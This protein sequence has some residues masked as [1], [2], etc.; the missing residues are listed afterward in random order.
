[1]LDDLGLIP[2]LHSFCKSLATR[3]KL[4]IQLTAFGG[5]EA[6]A[7]DKRTVLFRVAQEAL[8]NVARHARAT[9]VKFTIVKIPG[10]IRL[11]IGDNGKSF[12]VREILHAKTNKRLGLVGMKE[13][14]EMIGGSLTIESTP[15][16]GTTVRAEIP[17][18][19]EKTKS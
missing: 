10:A 13:R 8:N 11:E 12:P 6:L 16:K 19:P 14:V 17:F 3:K 2:A 7:G 9:R 1:V 4:K 15:G 18:T 5:V